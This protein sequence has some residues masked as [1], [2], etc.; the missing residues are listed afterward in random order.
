VKTRVRRSSV[1]DNL[2]YLH[3]EKGISLNSSDVCIEFISSSYESKKDFLRMIKYHDVN[4]AINV[5][6]MK[7]LN[8]EVNN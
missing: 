2:Y 6:M 3:K 1:D 4:N 8:A 7:Y 5:N